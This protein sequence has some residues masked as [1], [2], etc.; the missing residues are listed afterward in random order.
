MNLLVEVEL[1]EIEIFIVILISSSANSHIRWIKYELLISS[2]DR[3]IDVPLV[4]I[5]YEE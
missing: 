4:V 3:I 2:S 1:W 5:K